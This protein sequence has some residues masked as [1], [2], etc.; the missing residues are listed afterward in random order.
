MN[1]AGSDYLA[2]IT[3]PRLLGLDV[4]GL[5]VLG[6]DVLGLDV[7][8]L[9][10]LGIDLLGL[11]DANKLFQCACIKTSVSERKTRQRPGFSGGP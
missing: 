11:A 7:L 6:L 9:D 2:P 3:W 10:L 5:D 1:F 4:L 8:G